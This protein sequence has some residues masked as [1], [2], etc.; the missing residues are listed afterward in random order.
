MCRLETLAH[1]AQAMCSSAD[2]C[3][4][5]GSEEPYFKGKPTEGFHQ[6]SISR[7][8]RIILVTEIH[9]GKVLGT[10]SSVSGSLLRRFSQLLP[11]NN[12]DLL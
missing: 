6:Y 11:I 9:N 5:T 8:S 12:W 2:N 7:T 1:S 10:G 3:H 4:K